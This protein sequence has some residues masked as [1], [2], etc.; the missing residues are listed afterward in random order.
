VAEPLPP[1]AAPALDLSGAWRAHEQVADL[2]RQFTE[3][4][5]S[6][7]DWPTVSVP[8]HWRD[9]ADF[10]SSD[11]PVLY[12]RAFAPTP[13]TPGDRRFLTLDGVFYY[14]D[15]WL[16]GGYLGATEGYFFPHAFEITDA[17][18]RAPE[19]G[20]TVAV[21]VACPPQT[22]RANKRAITGV[23]SHWDNLDPA[24]NPGGIWRP[25][26]VRDT[27]PVRIKWLRVL[28]TEATEAHGRLRLDVTL[29]P[30][31]APEPVPLAAR[32]DAEITGPDGAVLATA[33]R[34]AMLAGGDNRLT[35]TIDV[36]QPPR[37]WPWRLGG[38]PRCAVTVTV[39]VDGRPSDARRLVTAFREVRWRDWRLTVNG[40]PL[41]AMGSN[42][43][44]SRM[45]LGAATP[46]ELARD[47]RLAIDT[48]LDLLRLHAHVTRPELYDAA[49]AAG[50]LL[51]QDFPLQWG[52]ARGTRKQAVRQAR[53]MVD[54][55]G[56]HPSVV[57]WCAHN[58]P[59]AVDLRPGEPMGTRKV[60][61][62]GAAMFLPSWNKDVLDLSVS[63]AIRKADPTR[64][65]DPHSGILPGFGTGGTDSHFYFGWYHGHMDG[66]APTLRAVPRLA[67]FV[68]EFG[69]QAVP[70]SAAFMEPQR[71]P[72]LDW[73]HLFAHHA[74]QKQYFDRVV[75]PALFDT[76]S[77][78]R[79]ATQQ[80]QAALI[81]L[82]VEDLRR[83]AG[84]PAGGFCHFCFADGHPGVTWSVLDHERRPKAGHA[85]LRDACR[86]VLPMLEPRR[87]QVHVANQLRTD[88][89]GVVV[90]AHLD[91][92]VRTFTGDVA[93]GAVAYVGAVHLDRRTGAVA[94]V[95]RHPEIG[96]IR[97][98]YDNLLEWLRIV[99]G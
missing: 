72:D 90:E 20:H 66:L 76:F 27:G 15:V 65:V 19:A 33:T 98:D 1:T 55:L 2:A 29:D 35:W 74:C 25:V 91:G 86:S 18:T 45:A 59:L 51:W 56:H 63:R 6:D 5:F 9:E 75:P 92:R 99:R 47:V 3:P 84:T 31:E 7:A 37:W 79:D 80:Y 41:F 85:A 54:L 13:L 82:Q 94:L 52:Y 39:T 32:L 97:N 30:G 11:G 68:T 40:E 62:I 50:L 34:D 36:E 4:A 57:L 89:E 87:G 8:G 83:I 69:A 48:N 53:E 38:Q 70:D 61:R 78:W 12:R 10:A 95:A 17:A 23:F 81:Q 64:A 60:A 22:D 77:A 44:P 14:G 28:C 93:A 58:E 16:D 21:E 46:A 26:R 49:D 88:L 43:G 96:E 71:W 24:W 42:Q 67:R 73:D